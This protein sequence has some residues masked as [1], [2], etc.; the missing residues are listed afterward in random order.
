MLQKLKTIKYIH[1]YTFKCRN[2]RVNNVTFDKYEWFGKGIFPT[3]V[4]TL[5]SFYISM[6]L[7]Y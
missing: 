3:L 7:T 5:V 1:A 4:V 2:N 6:L